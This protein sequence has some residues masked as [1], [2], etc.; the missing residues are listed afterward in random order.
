MTKHQSQIE[1]LISKLCPKGVEFKEMWE[2]TA[3]DKK[4]NGID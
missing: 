2:V 1:K 4:F 3:W